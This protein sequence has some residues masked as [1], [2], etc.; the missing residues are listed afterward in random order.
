MSMTLC[1]LPILYTLVRVVRPVVRRSLLYIVD[2]KYVEKYTFGPWTSE[3]KEKERREGP[4]TSENDKEGRGFARRGGSKIYGT[5]TR[6]CE[7]A[8][9][10]KYPGIAYQVCGG[11]RELFSGRVHQGSR[12]GDL[13]NIYGAQG[14]LP[15][16]NM[17]KNRIPERTSR[18]K[19]Y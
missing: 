7:A 8:L 5:S 19:K 18:G 11:V 3:E 13:Q 9:S 14:E 2:S 10:K 12:G 6:G 17:S 4:W 16:F 15:T 1:P